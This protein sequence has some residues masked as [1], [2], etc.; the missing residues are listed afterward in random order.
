MLVK[1]DQELV[2]RFKKKLIDDDLSYKI[3]IQARIQQYLREP[4]PSLS[5]VR[6]KFSD[7]SSL[8]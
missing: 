5:D 6:K 2:K 7:I 3:W 1:L 4:L 8:T